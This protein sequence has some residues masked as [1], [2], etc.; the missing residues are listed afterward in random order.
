MYTL[1]SCY[2]LINNY[3]YYSFDDITQF[4]IPKTFNKLTFSIKDYD[5]NDIILEEEIFLNL[6]FNLE[7]ININFFDNYTDLSQ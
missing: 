6:T 1:L 7:K 2:K 4:D 5:G 3:R